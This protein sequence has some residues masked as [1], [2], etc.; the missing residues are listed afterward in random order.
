MLCFLAS[1]F[2]EPPGICV[3]LSSWVWAQPCNSLLM[4]RIWQKYGMPFP[5]LGFPGSSVGKESLCNAGDPC[6]IS[7]SGRSAGEGIG[8]PL[9]YSWV[10]LVA[11]MVKNLPAMWETWVESLGWEDPLKKKMANHSAMLDWRIP[12]TEESGWL[13]FRESQRVRH[14]WSTPSTYMGFWG[15]DLQTSTWR[16][17]RAAV[18]VQCQAL[19]VHI[20]MDRDAWRAAIHGV[21]KSRTRLSDWSD[22]IWYVLMRADL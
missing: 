21:A 19:G 18:L 7:G 22:L 3:L 4:N 8:Y 1:L 12:W 9:Q 10:S 14:D 2:Q 20:R 11:Q 5:W 15:G 17:S 16:W 13:Q 6:S